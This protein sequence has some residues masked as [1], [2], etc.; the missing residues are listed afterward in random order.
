[1][2]Y[3]I[4]TVGGAVIDAFLTIHEG[5][6]SCQVDKETNTLQIPA[7][8]KILLDTYDFQLGGNACNVAVGLARAGL[9][10][11]LMAEFGSDEFGDKIWRNLQQE[12][13]EIELVQRSETQSSFSVGLNLQGERTLFI[14]HRE[15]NHNFSFTDL[16][17]R[18]M[19]LTSLGSKWQHVYER[20]EQFITK[21]PDVLL[22][23]NPGSR[24]YQDGVEH[25][26]SLLPLT[27]ILFVNKEEAQRIIGEKTEDVEILLK[28]LQM[29]GI[30]LVSITDGN[31]GS[32][33]ITEQGKIL[34]QPILTVPIVERTGAGDSY[35]AGFLAAYL[36]GKP[37][38][39]AMLWGTVN[40]GSVIGK[41][42][43]QP[44]LLR[45][46]ELAERSAQS[47]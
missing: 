19:Y 42:G 7:G 29:L 21:H 17:T 31:E 11:A 34:H 16:Q 20:A 4:V 5:N 46:D 8:E 14:A 6:T 43:A 24:Q 32:Y 3:D 44:G 36:L 37:I 23:F 25:F 30:Q 10:T 40:A 15:R 22:A 45:R 35:A 27:H 41:I 39:E 1:M 38:E 2:K 28:Q 12:G 47:R 33:L 26:R 9:K 18:A 13:V